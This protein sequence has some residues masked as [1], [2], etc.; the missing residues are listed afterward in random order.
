MADFSSTEKINASWKHLFGIVGTNNGSGSTGK[1]WYE[2]A[3]AASHVITPTDIWADNV[4]TATSISGAKVI[5]STSGS[6]VEDRS[7]GTNVILVTNGSDWDISCSFIPKIGYQLTN[8]HPNPTYIKSITNVIDLGSGNYTITLNSN[9]GVSAGLAVLHRRIY[10]TQDVSS[11]GKAWMTRS[12]Y[13]NSF[14]SIIQNFIQ[15][16]KFGNGYGVRLFQSNGSEIY[17]SQGAWIFNWQKGI[18]LFAEGFTASNLGYSTP[19]Y[20]ETFRYIGAFGGGSSIAPGDLHDT[21]RYDGTNWVP[22]SSVKSDGTNLSI[23]NRLTISG[24]VVLPSGT[25]PLTSGSSGS[26]G[27]FRWNNNFLFIHTELGWARVNLSYF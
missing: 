13:G 17:T 25:Q 3:I 21:I 23:L 7:D 26:F 27:E 9:S 10:L 4:Q 12:T 15:P 6:V 8:Q 11:N 18:L 19:L 16:T 5:A 20:I 24:S 22:T 14:S 2:E 1:T